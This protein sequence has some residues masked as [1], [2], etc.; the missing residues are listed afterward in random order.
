MSDECLN[1][2]NSHFGGVAFV[3]ENDVAVHPF[4]VGFFGAVG[5]VPCPQAV[6][7][8]VEEFFWHGGLGLA[9]RGII[10]KVNGGF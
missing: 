1:F 4:Y 7:G 10:S 6:A 3:V 5:V 9:I 8:L 2:W